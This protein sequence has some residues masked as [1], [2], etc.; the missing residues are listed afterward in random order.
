MAL[1]T[2]TSRRAVVMLVPLGLLLAGCG[3]G[4]GADTPSACLA[5]RAA[6]LKALEVAP[7]PVRLAGETPIS[8][9][10]VEDQAAGDLADV[11]A[12]LV[13]TATALSAAAEGSSGGAQTLRLGYLVGAAEEGAS[14]T[15]GIHAD[16]VRRIKASSSYLQ[17]RRSR[18]FDLT[19][20]RGYAAGRSEG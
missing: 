18:Q 12:S 17:P 10:L 16:L 14:E 3:S 11:G 5:G 9:C 19:Y 6:Y 7:D 15:S 20:A 1:R 13:G 2:R 4:D 8:N